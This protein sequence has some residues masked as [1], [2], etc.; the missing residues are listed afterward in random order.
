MQLFVGIETR[1]IAEG[2]DVTTQLVGHA[3]YISNVQRSKGNAY[4]FD[5]HRCNSMDGTGLSRYRAEG[6]YERRGMRKVETKRTPGG[7]SAN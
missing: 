4:K 2:L 3:R 5:E 6:P 7:W 1:Y